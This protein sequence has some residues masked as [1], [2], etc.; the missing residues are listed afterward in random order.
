MIKTRLQAIRRTKRIKDI[1]ELNQ[2]LKLLEA[3][4]KEIKR[5]TN[6]V[7]QYHNNTNDLKAI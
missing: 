1:R 7:L 6:A 4:T 2:Y 3:L 5:N